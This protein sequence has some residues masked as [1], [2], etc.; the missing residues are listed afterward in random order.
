[1]TEMYLVARSTA[2]AHAAG[3]SIVIGA[4]EILIAE[5]SK[6]I[7]FADSSAD[8]RHLVVRTPALSPTAARADHRPVPR[9]RLGL[10]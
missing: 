9:A 4:G 5:P 8:H 6:A 10:A 2:T 7:P 1:M 3:Q